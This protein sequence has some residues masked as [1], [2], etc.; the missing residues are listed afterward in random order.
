MPTVAERKP[1]MCSV[2]TVAPLESLVESIASV[3]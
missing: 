1:G 3:I 2:R